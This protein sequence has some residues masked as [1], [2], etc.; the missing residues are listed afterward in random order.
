MKCPMEKWTNGV[1]KNVHLTVHVFGNFFSKIYFC[2][3]VHFSFVPFTTA[4]PLLDEITH[5]TPSV[6][7]SVCLSHTRM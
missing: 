7:L 1:I 6:C 4:F 2:N 5:C 3:L